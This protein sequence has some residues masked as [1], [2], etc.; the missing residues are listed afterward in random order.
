MSASWWAPHSH[1]TGRW[2]AVLAVRLLCPLCASLC[3]RPTRRPRR[4][5]PGRWLGVWWLEWVAVGSAHTPLTMSL[6]CQAGGSA[7]G[8]GYTVAPAAR[9]HEEPFGVAEPQ[10][11][12]T[13][14]PLLVPGHG[15]TAYSAALGGGTGGSFLRAEPAPPVLSPA[16][17][18]PSTVPHH[19]AGGA[20][21][22]PA[23]PGAA[24]P[25]LPSGQPGCWWL[26]A[27]GPAAG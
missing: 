2:L 27:R 20:T 25:G 24:L 3:P 10:P 12:C 4:P 17:P 8:L 26:R 16:C 23:Q 11:R 1:P 21:P 19:E 9:G 22:S 15:M 18:M 7:P 13:A 6:T 14:H 5:L